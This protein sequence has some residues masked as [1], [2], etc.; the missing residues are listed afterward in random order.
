[1]LRLNF[2]RVTVT[3]SLNETF[4]NKQ[5]HIKTIDTHYFISL[6]RSSRCHIPFAIEKRMDAG[7]HGPNDTLANKKVTGARHLYQCCLRD[8][9]EDMF[10]IDKRID[11]IIGA[12][13]NN[14]RNE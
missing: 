1:M 6:C 8:G 14:N 13:K 2:D 10:V 11:R 7:K 5:Q 12:L 4:N 9:F 3:R